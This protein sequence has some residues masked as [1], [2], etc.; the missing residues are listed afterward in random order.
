MSDPP[1]LLPSNDP[2]NTLASNI[3]TFQTIILHNF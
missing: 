2:K 3:V 1:T